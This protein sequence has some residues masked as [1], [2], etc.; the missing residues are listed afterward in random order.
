MVHERFGKLNEKSIT[1]PEFKLPTVRH[2]HRRRRTP[3]IVFIG[4]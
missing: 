3:R 2:R 1:V 4:M